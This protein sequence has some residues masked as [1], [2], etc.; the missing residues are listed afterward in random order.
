MPQGFAGGNQPDAP[1]NYPAEY[2]GGMGA[3]DPYMDSM[4]TM[5]AMQGG[6]IGAGS[7]MMQRYQQQMQ[8]PNAM[9]A[10]MT[11]RAL[12]QP[13]ELARLA[14]GRAGTALAG[15]GLAASMIPTGMTI[16]QNIQGVSGAM[17]ELPYARLMH[18][19]QM[20]QPGMQ[21]QIGQANVMK[22]LAQAEMF[23]GR[24]LAQVEAQRQRDLMETQYQAQFR[25]ESG[26]EIPAIQMAPAAEPSGR[27]KQGELTYGVLRN[28]PVTD[29]KTGQVIRMDQQYVPQ[30]NK[31][32]YDQ[33]YGTGGTTAQG[34]PKGARPF[35]GEED[36]QA[37]ITMARMHGDTRPEA[38]LRIEA[39]TNYTRAL[40]GAR[41]QGALPT[42][43]KRS[44]IQ[45]MRSNAKDDFDRSYAELTKKKA[46]TDY[47]ADAEAAGLT[48]DPNFNILTYKS[49]QDAARRQQADQLKDAYGRWSQ[50]E[51]PTSI[52][53]FRDYYN[54]QIGQPTGAQP[55]PAGGQRIPTYNPA[56]GRI[57]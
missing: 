12:G 39:T 33:W 6:G 9:L 10:A 52:G 51:D 8:A 26:K 1:V 44:Q 45:T 42:E 23:G 18:A 50:I 5:Q 32:E 29:P 38:E 21:T 55:P 2:S 17:T 54:K 22:A 40:A 30:M 27:W 7:P 57:E 35:L 28:V 53:S 47:L 43:E 34:L 37:Y 4:L 14:P 31:K 19:Y 41:G 46:T 56:T 13:E 48:K 15:A 24:N 20:L 11:G 49:Q 3:G 36:V 25:A 16:G